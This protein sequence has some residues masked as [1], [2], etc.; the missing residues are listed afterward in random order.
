MLVKLWLGWKFNIDKLVEKY[1]DKK[2]SLE[3]STCGLGGWGGLAV[4]LGQLA[5][6]GTACKDK[7]IDIE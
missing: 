7:C 3:N 1:Y 6:I 5:P 4:V 2:I